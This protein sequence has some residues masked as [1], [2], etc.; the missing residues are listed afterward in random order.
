MK[1]SHTGLPQIVFR[2]SHYRKEWP[3][4]GVTATVCDCSLYQETLYFRA[5]TDV[6]RLYSI[7]SSGGAATELAFT[8]RDYGYIAVDSADLF[9]AEGTGIRRLSHDGAYS[10]EIV[11]NVE[12]VHLLAIDEKSVYFVQTKGAPPTYELWKVAK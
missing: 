11:T 10:E 3:P 2:E 7:S 4:D 9:V 8:S 1:A 5:A 6:A 12:G